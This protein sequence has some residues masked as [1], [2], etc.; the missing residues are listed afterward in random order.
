MTD[1]YEIALIGGLGLAAAWAFNEYVLKPSAAAG[2]AVGE[3]VKPFVESATYVETSVKGALEGFA[4]P[5]VPPTPVGYNP[6]N[7]TWQ[8]M[9]GVSL[10]LPPGMTPQEFCAGSKGSPIC[11]QNK[12][13]V[14]YGW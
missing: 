5:T 4:P 11:Q 2:K 9:N 3:A 12:N 6:S 13:F 14:G 10:G 1:I 8:L 7:W